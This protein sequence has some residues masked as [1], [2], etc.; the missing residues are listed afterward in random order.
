MQPKPIRSVSVEH[1]GDEYHVVL[2]NNVNQEIRPFSHRHVKEALTVASDYADF[3]GVRLT[4]FKI[5]G[6]VINP[7]RTETY[8]DARELSF[9]EYHQRYRMNDGSLNWNKVTHY[10]WPRLSKK[11]Q[12]KAKLREWLMPYVV[13]ID[14]ASEANRDAIRHWLTQNCI[15][16]W[17]PVTG[18]FRFSNDRDATLTKL[19]HHG[20]HDRTDP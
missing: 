6:R 20:S 12:T 19:Y 7:V 9:E 11:F 1:A 10:E 18:G 17:L 16:S 3:F 8:S 14:I 4:P 13:K 5:A 2:T 15:G